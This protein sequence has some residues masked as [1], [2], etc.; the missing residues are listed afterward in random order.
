MKR[1]A[2]SPIAKTGCY[3][4]RIHMAYETKVRKIGYSLG[5]VIPKDALEAM[6]VEEGTVLYLTH[7]TE[8][9]MRITP[10][11]PGFAEKM[12]IAERGMRKYRNALRELAK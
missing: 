4:D 3:N 6:R 7:S 9:A 2:K 10:E 11:R 12:A 1:D 8:G 5:I